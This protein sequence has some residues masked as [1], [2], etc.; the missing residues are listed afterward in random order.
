MKNK[1][2]KKIDKDKTGIFKKYIKRQSFE[3]VLIFK[4]NGQINKTC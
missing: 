2:K 4:F 1:V 3:N